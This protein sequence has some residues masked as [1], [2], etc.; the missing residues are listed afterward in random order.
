MNTGTSLDIK[1][2]KSE[3]EI[4][5]NMCRNLV[6]IANGKSG[7]SDHLGKSIFSQ[8]WKIEY[9]GKNTC[10]YGF[11]VSYYMKKQSKENKDLYIKIKVK[12]THGIINNK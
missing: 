12:E 10:I 5:P 2:I 9:K 11:Y 1:I 8:K 6:Y 4:N 3:I 7:I